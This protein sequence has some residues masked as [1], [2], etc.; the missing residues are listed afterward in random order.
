MTPIL[1]LAAGQSSRMRGRD[2][3]LEDMGGEPLLHRQVRMALATGAPTYVALP[4]NDSL[5]HRSISD[6]PVTA[7]NIDNPHDGLSVTLRE[8]VPKLATA[9][10]FMVFL[11]DLV[12]LEVSDL[13]KVLQARH[14]HPDHLIW[15]GATE[16][17]HP[18]HPILF[19]DRLRGDFDKLTGDAG[20]QSIVDAHQAQTYL[21][22]L[23]GQRARLDL[24]TPED[25]A[26]WRDAKR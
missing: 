21:V 22:E 13:R 11:A 23:P 25:W 16:D 15:R 12:T 9:G 6:L 10:A 19:D 18:G 1:I 7:L 4:K 20:A 2:K 24:D 17:G 14:S 3:L 8:A 5:R 26:A